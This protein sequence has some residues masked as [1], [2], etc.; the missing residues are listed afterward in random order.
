MTLTHRAPLSSV[1]AQLGRALSAA[2]S[3]RPIDHDPIFLPDFP[4][5][6]PDL[7]FEMGYRKGHDR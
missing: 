6:T 1:L 7:A 4:M 2:S 5:L 3:D